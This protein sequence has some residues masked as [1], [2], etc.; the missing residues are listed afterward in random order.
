MLSPF[1][2]QECTCS[3]GFIFL[4][5]SRVFCQHAAVTFCCVVL[6]TPIRM[7]LSSQAKR[8]LDAMGANIWT[9]PV[10]FGAPLG[11]SGNH[12]VAYSSEYRRADPIRFGNDSY[13]SAV[14]IEVCLHAEHED[15]IS[16]QSA[17]HHVDQPPPAPHSSSPRPRYFLSVNHRHQVSEAD[18]EHKSVAVAATHLLVPVR[19]HRSD[20]QLV[21]PPVH[22]KCFRVY[23]GAKFQCVEYARRYLIMTHHISF[24]S[25][26]MAF[27]IFIAMPHFSQL[28]FSLK[29]DDAYSDGSSTRS[30]TVPSIDAATLQDDAVKSINASL[31]LEDKRALSRRLFSKSTTDSSPHRLIDDDNDD[32]WM[33]GH[34][35]PVP[36]S[37]VIWGPGGYFKHT[38]HVA[39]VVAVDHE[40]V[41]ISE[42]NVTDCVWPDGRPYA[43]SFAL[44]VH[45]GSPTRGTAVS[46][47]AAG[48]PPPGRDAER[49]AM[50]YGVTESFF[51]GTLWGWVTPKS[52]LRKLA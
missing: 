38:G 39:V 41:Y 37:L 5:V 30:R 6:N 34:H 32:A 43:R 28:Q 31:P 49:N 23:A 50:F 22:A 4:C 13:E 48:S 25:L 21:P 19:H 44:E 16:P 29:D 35:A 36:G 17:L 3:C 14:D 9:R 11:V 45:P 51:S 24:P 33:Q 27:H 46:C 18:P 42:Q 10:D 20:H 15:E 47:S 40:R 7:P 2:F 8:S 12:V 26:P 1:V 52:L